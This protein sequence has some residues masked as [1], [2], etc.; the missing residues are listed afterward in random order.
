MPCIWSQPCKILQHA[1]P[2]KSNPIHS[3][4]R[5]Y[6]ALSSSQRNQLQA[7]RSGLNKFSSWPNLQDENQ[8]QNAGKEIES[9]RNSSIIGIRF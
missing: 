4:R 7:Q 2:P 6:A 3:I 1:E 9:N 5:H 8:I